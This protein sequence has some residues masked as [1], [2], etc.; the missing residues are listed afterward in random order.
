MVYECNTGNTSGSFRMFWASASGHPDRHRVC[1]FLGDLF[2]HVWGQWDASRFETSWHLSRHP[3]GRRQLNIYL[4]RHPRT[5][6]G[7]RNPG[8]E[9]SGYFVICSDASVDI[10]ISH[11]KV[12]YLSRRQNTCTLIVKFETSRSSVDIFISSAISSNFETSR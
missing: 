9:T 11:K 5:F 12:G 8:R 7:I 4:C 1:L 6:G 3:Y 10:R 2:R